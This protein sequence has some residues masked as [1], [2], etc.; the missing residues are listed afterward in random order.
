[1]HKEKEIGYRI[2]ELRREKDGTMK[3][4]EREEK[5]QLAKITTQHRKRGVQR[6]C[7]CLD[8]ENNSYFYSQ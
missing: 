4:E 5:K 7:H 3:T 1:M 2:E 6:P 8:L